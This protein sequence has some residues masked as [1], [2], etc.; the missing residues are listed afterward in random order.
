MNYD[1]IFIFGCSFTKYK[2]PTW[3]DIIGYCKNVPPIQ[4]WG[5]EGIGNVAIMH[6]MLECDLKNKFTDRDLILVQWSTWTREDRF[7][8]EWGDGGSV[9]NNPRFD[10]H[11]I[12]KHWH[13]NND[14]V[15]NST[16]IIS[17]NRMFNIGF[18]YTFYDYQS[19]P[20]FGYEAKDHLTEFENLYRSNLPKIGKFPFHVN[21]NFEHRCHDGHGDIK[22]HLHLFNTELKPRFGFELGDMEPKL[23]SLNDRIVQ[24]LD[25]KQNPGEQYDIIRRLVKDF[26][27]NINEKVTLGF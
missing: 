11:F 24:H 7:T 2:W 20:D 4:N 14:I 15:K 8:T 9:F 6:K 3:A 13:W 23:I 17:A 5:K 19:S 21:T 1:R 27:S 26:D 25:P 18:Q 10:K 12:N 16:A 22:A